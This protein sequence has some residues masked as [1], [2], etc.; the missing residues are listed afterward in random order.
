VQDRE[1]ILS[2]KMK[3]FVTR[4]KKAKGAWQRAM[5]YQFK[6]EVGFPQKSRKDLMQ[7]CILLPLIWV[8]FLFCLA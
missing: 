6:Q 1:R 2:E 8:A 4:L 5:A 7:P 3:V